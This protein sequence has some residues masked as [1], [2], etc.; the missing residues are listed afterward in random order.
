MKNEGFRWMRMAGATALLLAL[1]LQAQE[2]RKWYVRADAGG[3][4]LNNTDVEEFLGPAGGEMEFDAGFVFGIAGGYHVTPWLAVEL[5]TG[6]SINGV[7][8][9]DAAITQAPFTANVIYECNH[10]GKFVPFLGAGV[11]G[12]TTIFSVDD[13]LSSGEGSVYMDG[14]DA[15][16]VFAY[17]AF[18]GFRYEFND[19]MSLGF[20]YRFRGTE[21]PS[22]DVE[23]DFTGGTIGEIRLDNIYTHT[24]SVLFRMEF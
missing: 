10:C 16:F 2:D 14:S 6:Y 19:R 1:A 5:E 15:D 9:L 24:F 8:G 20:L 13:T 23:D 21:G 17:Q 18:G 4:L 11:G 22:W 12:A 3:T 7:H